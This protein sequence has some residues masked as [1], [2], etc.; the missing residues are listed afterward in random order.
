MAESA[1]AFRDIAN[2]HT[3]PSARVVCTVGTV[4]TEPGIVTAVPGVC[5][6]SLDQRALDATVLAKM[7]D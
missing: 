7:L 2:R 5:E 6:I 3:T 4:R 1:L